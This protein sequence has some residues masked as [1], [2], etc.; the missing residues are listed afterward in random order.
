MIDDIKHTHKHVYMQYLNETRR[1]SQFM[2]DTK[3]PPAH[4]TQYVN[5][6]VIQPVT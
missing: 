5:E 4:A 2:V 6:T 3:S 1:P